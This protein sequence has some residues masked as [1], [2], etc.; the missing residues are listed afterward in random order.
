MPG[1][2]PASRPGRERRG[3]PGGSSGS[4]IL[5]ALAGTC[6]G[7]DPNRL[8]ALWYIS[9]TRSR[10]TPPV[11]ELTYWAILGSV[12]VCDGLLTGG[13]MPLTRGV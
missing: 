8:V 4:A 9:A 7:S 10:A 5:P 6:P 1:G 2:A 13:L 12:P 11:F 3:H